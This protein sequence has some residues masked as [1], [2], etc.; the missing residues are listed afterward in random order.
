MRKSG[1]L[2]SEMKKLYVVIDTNVLVSAMFARHP[3]SA[4]VQILDRLFDKDIIPMYNDEI[5][6]E[7][8]D[9]LH[10]PKFPFS[11]ENI[12]LMINAI[13]E[14]GI[15]SGRIATSDLLKDP[16]DVVFYEVAMSRNDSYLVTGNIKD[17]P[18]TPKVVTPVEL[19]DILRMLEMAEEKE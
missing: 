13:I 8:N 9:V 11:E 4:P 10:R 18:V 14:T 12:V 1:L 2:G 17:F 19:L 7:Y 3:D 5:L 15:S 16:K 6:S